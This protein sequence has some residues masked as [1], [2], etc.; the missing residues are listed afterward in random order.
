MHYDKNDEKQAC[1]EKVHMRTTPSFLSLIVL[2]GLF[3]FCAASYFQMDASSESAR[4]LLPLMGGT[5]F[6]IAGISAFRTWKKKRIR[7]TIKKKYL[8]HSDRQEY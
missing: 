2:I 6:L 5:L 4:A 7:E 3:I 1:P 8:T